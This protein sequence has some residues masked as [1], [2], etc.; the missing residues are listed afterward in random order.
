[1]TLADII[2]RIG[3]RVAALREARASVALPERK[4]A[5]QPEPADAPAAETCE[6]P[7]YA[8]LVRTSTA[9]T[10]RDLAQAEAHAAQLREQ[11][12]QWVPVRVAVVDIPMAVAELRQEFLAQLTER[13][14][15]RH[16][17]G[18]A[19]QRERGLGA[20]GRPLHRGADQ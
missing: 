15:W 19:W 8:V 14:R 3:E 6:V 16:E 5:R 9:A 11:L 20:D 7:H 10:Y 17:Q 2:A 1:M 18:A 4:P 12:G 13:A